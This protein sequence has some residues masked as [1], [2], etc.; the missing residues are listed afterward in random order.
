MLHAFTAIGQGTRLVL[1]PGMRRFVIAPVAINLLIYAV[2]LGYLFTHFGGWLDYWML[3]VPSWLDWLE[4]L[5]WPLLV[6]SLLLVVFFSFTLVTNLIAAP[7]YGFLAEKVEWR[8][9][10]APP[11]D[12][13]GLF[14]AGV[15]A[16][17]REFVKLGYMLPR[18][19]LLF[20]FG[21]VPGVNIFMPFL[22]AAFSAWMLAIQY[23]DY[24][25]DNNQVSFR[26]MRHRLRTRL[27]PTLTF[28]F[29]MSFATWVPVL[30][31]VL[32]PGGV[33]GAVILWRQY[34]RH[35]PTVTR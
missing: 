2:T 21:F 33:A 15:D 6:V 20:V 4:W 29:G 26:D 19:A 32:L 28:G 17:G 10:G 3:Q 27:W 18:M 31:L 1:S 11:S 5:I 9:S 34:Y 23:L 25:M 12:T 8:L 35:L 22:W 13:R 30:N 14:R 16:L 24:P 7:F